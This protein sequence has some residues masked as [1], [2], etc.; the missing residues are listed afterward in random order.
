MK[1]HD[2]VIEMTQ[3]FPGLKRILWCAAGLAVITA[4]FPA[5]AAAQYSIDWYTVDG[6]GETKLHGGSYMV[7]STIGQ[8][9]AGVMTGGGYSLSGGFWRGGTQIIVGVDDGDDVGD[10]VT[11][12]VPLAFRLHGA[13][14]NPLVR[15][16]VIAF[17]LPAARFVRMRIFDASGRV[18]KTLVEGSLPA[19]RHHRS[20]EGVDD[21][22]RPVAAGIYFV[23]FDSETDHASRKIVVLH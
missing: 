5:P 3:C 7:G 18:A 11:T 22:G 9:D 21:A 15:N 19:G 14:P 6:G 8:A 1:I 4:A 2:S 20:W 16:S 12:D 23:R 13:S 17:D 10:G